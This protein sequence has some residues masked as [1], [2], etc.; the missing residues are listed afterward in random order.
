MIAISPSWYWTLPLA[1]AL[2]TL[3][4]MG[5]YYSVSRPANPRG[6]GRARLYRCLDCRH[7][8][9]DRRNV[10]LSACP[11]CSTLNEAVRK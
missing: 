9:E 4:M 10:P 1:L 2:A 5:L 11:R 7:V 3:V 6:R 8:Y